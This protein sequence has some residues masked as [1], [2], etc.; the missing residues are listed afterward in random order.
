MG[1]G[2]QQG[3]SALAGR[4]G[5]CMEDA[6]CPM[7]SLLPSEIVA[8]GLKLCMSLAALMEA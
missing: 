8:F 5:F 1:G 6:L 3:A 4:G 7:A 2:G